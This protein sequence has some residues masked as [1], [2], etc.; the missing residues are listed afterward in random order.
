M[1]KN[2]KKIELL[3][4]EKYVKYSGGICPACRKNTITSDSIEAEGSSAWANCRC[5]SCGAEWTDH[6][7]LT[8]YGELTKGE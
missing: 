7:T 3:T 5:S 8:G 6:Y 4:E 1:A 2:T